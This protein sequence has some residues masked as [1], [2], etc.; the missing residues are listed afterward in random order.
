MN[1]WTRKFSW[2]CIEIPR[3]FVVHL[4]LLLVF[5]CLRLPLVKVVVVV[6][7]SSLAVAL[8]VFFCLLFSSMQNNIR[9][10]TVWELFRDNRQLSLQPLKSYGLSEDLQL[11]QKLYEASI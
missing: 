8:L 3:H 1:A 7:C 10:E 6:F 5:W 11:R 9:L 2:L 4:W